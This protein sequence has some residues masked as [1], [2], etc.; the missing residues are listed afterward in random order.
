MLAAALLHVRVAYSQPA[1][2]VRRRSCCLLLLLACSSC[3]QGATGIYDAAI[4]QCQQL[5]PSPSLE[6]FV[7]K[8][9]RPKVIRI[10]NA[11]QITIGAFKIQQKLHRDL[12]PTTLYAYGTNS[13]TASYPGPRIEVIQNVPSNIRWENH[14]TDGKHMLANDESLMWANPQSGGI[15][16]VTHLHGAEVHSSSDGHPDAWFTAGGSHGSTYTTQNYTYPNA[17]PATMLWYH[18]H[19]FGITRLNVLAGLAGLYIIRSKEDPPAWMPTGKFEVQLVV[20]DKQFFFNG[21]IN[22][23]NVGDSPALHPQWCPEYFGDT[24]LV[25]GKAWPYL[26]VKPQMY[27]FRILNAANARVFELSMDNLSFTQI[28]TDQELLEKPQSLKTLT[29]APGERVDCIVDFST[30]ANSEVILRNDGQA[31]YPEGDP[32]FSPES[33]RSVMKF[34]ISKANSSTQ[35]QAAPVPATLREPQSLVS[36]QNAKEWRRNFMFEMDDSE[37]N[38]MS[39]LLSNLTWMDPVTETPHQGAIEVWE[40]INLTPDAHPMHIHLV[41]FRM[42]SQQEFNLTLWREG[43]CQLNDSSCFLG[44]PSPALAH[45]VG[46]KDTILAMPNY[47]TRVVMQWTAH[48]GGAFGFDVSSGPGYLWHCHILDHE[49]NDMMRPIRVVADVVRPSAMVSMGAR[50]QLSGALRLSF[51]LLLVLFS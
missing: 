35:T 44:A 14:I 32:A 45:Q 11:K 43:A 29:I 21:S 7:D 16:I 13:D 41:H 6:K 30:A 18:D 42:L 9:P 51:L 49:D 4:S 38:P 27:R 33:T 24:V 17:Q 1:M 2:A 26:E 48:N 36:S 10:S 20:Q 28:G 39:S 50:R 19:A 23:P 3:F 46:P 8:L 5:A 34:I 22:F 25:N 31:P 40:F 37:G 12:P 15:P 47:V